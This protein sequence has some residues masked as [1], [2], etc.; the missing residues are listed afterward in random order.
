[1]LSESTGLSLE[2]GEGS[3][4]LVGSGAP[5]GGEVVSFGL[6]LLP[7]ALGVD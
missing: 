3:M 6:E 4:V 7:V 5:P 2:L 1:M